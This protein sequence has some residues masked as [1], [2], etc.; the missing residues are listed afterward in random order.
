MLSAALV[1]SSPNAINRS[2]PPTKPL[3][4]EQ[5]ERPLELQY[6]FC[7]SSRKMSDSPAQP[8]LRPENPRADSGGRGSGLTVWAKKKEIVTCAFEPADSSSDNP[9]RGFVPPEMVKARPVV[10]LSTVTSG[11]F[12]V[13]PLST[14][15]PEPVKSFHYELRWDTPLP[16]W[17]GNSSCW[18]KGDMIYTV[19]QKRV[20]FLKTRY[21]RKNRKREPIRRYL[22]EDQ[23]QGVRNAV[24]EALKEVL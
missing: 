2:P 11:L 18:V 1:P 6:A 8:L 23:W 15:K 13:T 19:S 10:V 16:G 4:P 20:D 14:T 7:T 17:E 21:N 12:V 9:L 22:S 24:R 3:A 5:L